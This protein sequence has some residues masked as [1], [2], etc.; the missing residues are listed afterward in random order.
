MEQKWSRTVVRACLSSSPGCE[1]GNILRRHLRD[2]CECNFESGPT[3]PQPQHPASLSSTDTPS[4]LGH[5]AS[6]AIQWKRSIIA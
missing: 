2:S 6:L 4:G 5:K 1:E 3:T